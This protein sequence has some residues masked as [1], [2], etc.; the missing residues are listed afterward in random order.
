[1]VNR[2]ARVLLLCLVLLFTANAVFAQVDT[3][4]VS[5][6][7]KA[8]TPAADSARRLK[9][10][11][12]VPLKIAVLA[13]IYLDSVFYDNDYTGGNIVPAYVLPGLDFYNG[14]MMAIDSLQKEHV[15]VEVWIYDT[16][17]KFETTEMLKAELSI[18]NFSLI[19][20]CVSNAMEQK[21]LGEFAFNHNIPFISGTYPNDAGLSG[22]PFYAIANPTIKCHAQAIYNYVQR[23]YVGNKVYYVTKQGGMEQRIKGYFDG[24]KSTNYPLK[25]TPVTLPASFKAADLLPFIDSTSDGVIVCGSL[26]EAFGTALIKTINNS[27]LA[28]TV[29][30]VGMPTWDNMG[31]LYSEDSK[32]VSV[33]YS[34][35][36][37]YNRKNTLL[38][39]LSNQYRS[40]F[41]GRPSDMVFKGFEQVYHFTH[42]LVKYRDSLFSNLSDTSF[43]IANDYNFQPVRLTA[44]SHAPD[45]LEN[46]KLYFIK[47]QGGS[48]KN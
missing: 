10:D 20:G 4:I 12:T 16:K 6:A 21:E 47:M 31:I 9:A 18:N 34:T 36:Y 33:V 22:N 25:Y 27:A 24:M 2:C 7:P 45:F 44:A 40:K 15:P 43:K 29:T 1:M 13:P 39:S 19:I 8:V 35:P 11:S 32:N 5:P 26:D 38:A 23:N 17:K 30:I 14:V 37:N 48:V 28:K 42:L 3:I 46:K 41:N